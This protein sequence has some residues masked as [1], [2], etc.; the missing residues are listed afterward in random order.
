[1]NPFDLSGKN[2]L[3]TGA[4]SGIGKQSAIT[5]SEMGGKVFITGKD[6]IRLA[7]TI[8]GLKGEGHKSFSADLTKEDELLNF[9]NKVPQINGVVLCAGITTHMPT[10][11]IQSSNITE[12]FKINYESV[13]LLISKLLYKKKIENKSSIVFLSSI[14]TKHA[15]FG[16]ALYTGTKSAIESYSKTLALELAPKGIRTNCLSPTFV[17]TEMINKA[18][19]TI[20]SESLEKMKKMHPLGFGDPVDVAN[21]IVFFLSDASKWISGTNLELGGL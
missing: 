10:N 7:Q 16:G 18:E 17:K 1:M 9:I 20:S 2:I 6:K 5:I 14:A 13:V 8:Q 21:T 15:Y 3:I 4:S 11:F 19:K 12:I